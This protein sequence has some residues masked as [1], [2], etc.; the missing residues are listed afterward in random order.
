MAMQAKP[1]SSAP[2]GTATSG[3]PGSRCAPR[4]AGCPRT[5]GMPHHT[6]RQHE[7]EREHQR[8]QLY[9]RRVNARAAPKAWKT[10]GTQR[11]VEVRATPLRDAEVEE[12]PAQDEEGDR[13]L[14]P[15]ERAAEHVAPHHL[16]Q[17]EQRGAER[18]AARRRAPGRGPGTPARRRTPSPRPPLPDDA[19][20][21]ACFEQSI[22][23]IHEEPGGFARESSWPS[24][25]KLSTSCWP[26]S[27]AACS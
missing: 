3:T 13:V 19:I 4:T 6:T 27:A 2:R 12:Y 1:K 16:E 9:T 10:R 26:A 17:R 7:R 8:E 21:E 25:L 15:L 24:F 11:D 14:L 22:F 5:S 18:T 23:S 20:F